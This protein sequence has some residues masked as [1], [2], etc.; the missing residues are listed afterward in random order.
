[1]KTEVLII[2]GGIAG[3]SL[4]VL[5]G[6]AGLE[7]SVVEPRPL[8][9]DNVDKHYGRTA[10]LM[11][12][13]VNILK[14]L[15]LWAGLQEQ[16]APLKTMRIIDDS[17]PNDDPIQIDFKASEI[18][19]DYFG[20]NIPNM[21]LHTKLAEKVKSIKNISL[22]ETKLENFQTNKNV[23]IATLE[24]GKTITTKLL[25]GADGRN[26]EVR[27]LSNIT[28]QEND[29]QQSAITC[30]IEHSKSHDNISTEHHRP[31]GPFTT[32]PMPDK[33][34][35]HYSSVVWVEKTTDADNFI[36]LNKPAFEKALQTRTRNA[37]GEI[38]LAS[39]PECWPLKGIIADE[40]TAPRTALIAEAA[41]AM[42]P[43]AAQGLNLSLRDVATLSEII[44][45]ALR[46][47]EDIG[48]AN[49]LNIYAKKRRFDM[50]T[51][52]H[53][54]DSYNRIVS[55]NLGF[56]RSFRKAG[57]KTL[58][59]VPVFKNLAMQHGLQPTNDDSRLMRGEAL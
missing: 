31:G 2:G 55:N 45:D 32:V 34:G 42:S 9:F 52:Y 50:M 40:I 20:H 28:Y 10:A 36:K 8:K 43:I 51:R 58:E 23:V 21:M 12:G 27:K 37:L 14:S 57:L 46:L 16:T 11:G 59:S 3:L 24:N 5:L 15:G 54:V 1:M 48:S 41:H 4:A 33:D 19:R 44:M 47:G 29:Y 25:V 56:L 38:K 53:G 6:N 7:V 35:K 39:N 22:H 26:S 13:S 30:L 17:N 49:T 18:D